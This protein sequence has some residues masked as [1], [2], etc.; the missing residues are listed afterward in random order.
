LRLPEILPGSPVKGLSEQVL[1][2]ITRRAGFAVVAGQAR[3]RGL[4]F[5]TALASSK[6]TIAVFALENLES[7]VK[8]FQKN[9]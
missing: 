3:L 4:L 9:F 5:K 7:R 8:F 6:A 2:F 1:I